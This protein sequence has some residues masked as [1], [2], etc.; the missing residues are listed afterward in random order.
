MNHFKTSWHGI[1]TVAAFAISISGAAESLIRGEENLAQLGAFDLETLLNIEVTSAS[2]KE[3][4]LSETAAAI[5]V[6]TSEDIR[7][8]GFS[9]LPDVFRMVPGMQVARVNAN[10]WAISSRGFN[11]PYSNKLL[12]LVDGRTVYTPSFGGVF[13]S[14]QDLVLEDLE[15]IEVIRGPGATL[16]GANAFNGVINII[17]KQAKDTQGLLTSTSY[18]NLEQPVSSLRYGAKIGDNLHYRVYGRYLSHES[19]E[20]GAGENLGDDWRMGSGGTRWDWDFSESDLLTVQG[21]F[22]RGTV[23]DLHATPQLTPPYFS[24]VATDNENTSANILARWTHRY[25]E[26]NEFSLQAY[27]DRLEHGELESKTRENTFDLDL[28]HRF[29][30]GERN[31]IIWGG[32]YR[33][34]PGELLNPGQIRWTEAESHHQLA[35]I[36]VQDELTVIPDQL[37]FTLGSKFEHNDF[38]GLEIQP[39]ARLHYTPTEKQSIWAAASRAVRIPTLLDTRLEVDLGVLPATPTTPPVMLRLTGNPEIGVEEVFAYELG[40][41]VRPHK[42]LSID[43]AGFFNVFNG[44]SE[45]QPTGVTFETDPGPHLVAEAVARNAIDGFNYGAEV[46]ID[47]AVT[48][49]WRLHASYG[50]IDF[51]LD[52]SDAPS[53]S[54]PEHQAQLRSYLALPG[55]VELI[56]AVYYVDSVLPSNGMEDIEI[57]SYVRLDLGITWRPRERLELG[58]WGQNLLDNKHPESANFRLRSV[59][60]VPRSVVG[61]VTWSY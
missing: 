56:G 14:D 11:G 51:D 13:W 52:P 7:R 17:S 10:Q 29:V 46:A 38:S 30:L 35:N 37:L 43:A 41:R 25:S 36:F 55:H 53:Y 60:E 5:Y 42:R 61:R 9:T 27:Y 16:W 15:R 48:D 47:F 50:W 59:A 31:E 19:F 54:T 24:N 28:R 21:D 4:K 49:R 40:Y 33:Y 20:N 1:A 6:I 45:Y 22:H 34:L 3:Q 18:G 57:P 44:L 2:K 39:S 23:G 32:G 58:L 8:S 12:V 26:D